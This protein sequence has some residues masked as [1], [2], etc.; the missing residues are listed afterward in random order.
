MKK[1]KDDIL[2]GVPDSARI[3]FARGGWS[4]LVN[5]SRRVVDPERYQGRALPILLRERWS[6]RS[7]IPA[8]DGTYF[9]LSRSSAHADMD[10]PPSSRAMGLG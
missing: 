8:G 3:V 5:E 6:I 2:A 1:A 10:E 7:T 9:V 4:E